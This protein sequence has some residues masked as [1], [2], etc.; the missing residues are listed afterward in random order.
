[1]QVGG[2]LGLGNGAHKLSQIWALLLLIVQN[3]VYALRGLGATYGLRSLV[4]TVPFVHG[5]VAFTLG[6]QQ[7]VVRGKG[8][9]MHRPSQLDLTGR[10]INK[11]GW[12]AAVGSRLGWHGSNDTC[13][14][15]AHR[16][17]T[18]QQGQNGSLKQGGYDGQVLQKRV[19][20]VSNH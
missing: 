17:S 14:G 19:S 7:F 4:D 18:R 12:L 1:M 2:N 15:R 6:E 13:R 20:L 9:H 16:D 3:H 11:D 5:E 10:G 8:K